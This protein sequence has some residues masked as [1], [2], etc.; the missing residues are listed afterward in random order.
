V[1]CAPDQLLDL[2]CGS[3]ERIRGD[4]C[5]EGFAPV[6]GGVRRASRN[7]AVG[8]M[9]GG[10]PFSDRAYLIVKVEMECSAR[11]A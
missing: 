7:P 8:V 9:V 5:D 1:Q 4:V 6:I 3:S 11:D 10:L 2:K